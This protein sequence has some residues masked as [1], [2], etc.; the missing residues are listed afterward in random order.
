MVRPA[1]CGPVASLLRL[2]HQKSLSYRSASNR[3]LRCTAESSAI[4]TL[5]SGVHAMAPWPAWHTRCLHHGPR[6]LSTTTSTVFCNMIPVNCVLI[7]ETFDVLFSSTFPSPEKRTWSP[8]TTVQSSLTHIKYG[9]RF[10]LHS[11]REPKAGL[12]FCHVNVNATQLQAMPHENGRSTARSLD[13]PLT[14]F[15]QL[16]G[17]GG[18]NLLEISRPSPD[19]RIAFCLHTG[20][21]PIA[22]PGQDLFSPLSS[23]IKASRATPNS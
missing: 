15:N 11:R 22:Q 23:R 10:D 13:Q 8:F 19:D 1:C 2:H 5:Y 9:S 6:G 17:Q 4:K 18:F 7:S 3:V 16:H 14:L 12:K 21:R 20:P